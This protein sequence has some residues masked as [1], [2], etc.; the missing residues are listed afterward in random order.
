MKP[1]RLIIIIVLGLALAVLLTV[2]AAAQTFPDVPT[3]HSY[4]QAIEGMAARDIVGGYPSGYFGPSDLVKRQQFAKMIVLTMGYAVSENDSCP[5]PDVEHIPGDLYPFHYVAKAA[6]TG[7]TTGYANGTFG[8]A[9]QITRQQVVT[10]AVRAGGSE[11]EDPP[12]GW[13]GVLSYSDPH[14]RREHP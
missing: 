1:K 7:L 2:P 12:Q 10:M 9:N 13:A 11:L 14:A 3:S 4:Y 8:P 5:F 6:S